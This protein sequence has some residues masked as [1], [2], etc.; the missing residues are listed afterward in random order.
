MTTFIETFSPGAS[1]AAPR[2]L[3]LAARFFFYGCVG[4]TIEV[5]WTALYD[6]F[7]GTG[8]ARLVGTT[9]LWMHPIW[10]LCL[11]LVDVGYPY[12][13]SRG[14]TWL[15]RGM[16]WMLGTFAIEYFS[17]YLLRAL[18]GTAPWDYSGNLLNIDGLIRLDYAV[19]WMLC[20]LG[21]ERLSSF[22]RRVELGADTVAT[23]SRTG[24]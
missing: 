6:L 10:A 15:G 18:V 19:P 23:E 3:G 22:L 4:Y 11:T 14:I 12:F 24:R 2:R 16:I 21:A 5:V 9:Y 7:A 1:A 8:D 13:R 17:G 20:G